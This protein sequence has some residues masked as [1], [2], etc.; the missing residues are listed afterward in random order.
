MQLAGE[1]MAHHFVVLF[2]V[3]LKLCVAQR[4]LLGLGLFFLEGVSSRRAAN[5]PPRRRP[6]RVCAALAGGSACP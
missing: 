1:R 5:G 2:A 3:S 4:R 6:G